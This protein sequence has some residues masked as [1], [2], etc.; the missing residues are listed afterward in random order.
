[1]TKKLAPSQLVQKP[2]NVPQTRARGWILP[3]TWRSK[4]VLSQ[5]LFDCQA[6]IDKRTNKQLETTHH[7][8]SNKIS[9]PYPTTSFWSAIHNL[10]PFC[11]YFC[12]VLYTILHKN[13]CKLEI[14]FLSYLLCLAIKGLSLRFSHTWL[15]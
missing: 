1:M 14:V 6:Y 5:D 10:G 3:T 4:E 9:F 7:Y 15:D 8:P 11:T 2:E 13:C 12:S